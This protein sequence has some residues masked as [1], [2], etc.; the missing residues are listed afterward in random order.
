MDMQMGMVGGS[1]F[2][3]LSLAKGGITGNSLG[4]SE[5]VGEAGRHVGISVIR[6]SGRGYRKCIYWVVMRNA[7]PG[8]LILFRLL[9]RALMVMHSIRRL[10][11]FSH[12]LF[13]V[14][15]PVVFQC[16]FHSS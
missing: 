1:Y 3:K 12:G 7:F 14:S 16:A 13:I 11:Q 15:L 6:I 9:T 4:V 2:N 8:K 10:R 5:I